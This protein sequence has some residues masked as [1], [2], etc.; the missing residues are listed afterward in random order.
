MKHLVVHKHSGFPISRGGTSLS[1]NSVIQGIT[2]PHT[3]FGTPPA[4]SVGT[5][6][7]IMVAVTLLSGF[8]LSH[9]AAMG[10]TWPDLSARDIGKP[11]PLIPETS[12]TQ[13][14]DALASIVVAVEKDLSAPEWTPT[15]GMSGKHVTE[16]PVAKPAPKQSK[17]ART[18]QI[19]ITQAKHTVKHPE[20]PH[21]PVASMKRLDRPFSRNE[22]A[23]RLWREG[24]LARERGEIAIAIRHF[25][26]AL[27][28]NSRHRQAR[29]D[30]MAVMI[31]Q[32]Q[33]DAARVLL[34]QAPI[35]LR[36]DPTL[37]RLRAHIAL[38]QG[39]TGEAIRLLETR[40]PI[41]SGH[42]AY[43]SLLASAL[44][45]DRQMERAAALYLRLIRENPGNAKSW[46]GLGVCLE[47]LGEDDQA[48]QA[49]RKASLIG[50]KALGIPQLA[51]DG[52]ARLAKRPAATR[53]PR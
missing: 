37:I 8:L 44:I 14:V 48:L 42:T 19:Q 15:N 17:P 18:S 12:I 52:I 31:D 53:V 40:P 9:W 25:N 6:I 29:I 11:G 22:K 7:G 46:L 33:P 47:A 13:D 24:A 35:N 21:S 23:Q 27:S 30:L 5:T 3:G 32:G 41:L 1:S 20:P 2:L 50:D 34:Q 51:V 26:E 49:Y 16:T 43:F 28:H 45:R 10:H 36:Q 39:N 4:R 38:Q